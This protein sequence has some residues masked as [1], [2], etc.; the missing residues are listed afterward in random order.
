[1]GLVIMQ[2]ELRFH[3]EATSIDIPQIDAKLKTRIKHAIE[4]K[5]T[6]EP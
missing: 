6:T 1:M 5:L 4:T 2:F 3:P